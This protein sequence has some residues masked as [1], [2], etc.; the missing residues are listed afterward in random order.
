[1]TFE[2]LFLQFICFQDGSGTITTK[3]LLPVLRS[4][5]QNPTEDEI[6]N[7]VIEYD[8]N[9]DGTI[10]F[11][12]FLEMMIKHSKDIDQTLEI[13]EA[14]KIFDRDGNGYIDAKELKHVVTRM[15]HVLT[16]A[17][18]D[19]FMKEAD[20]DGDGKLDYNEFM[21]MMLESL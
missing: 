2:W 20:L 10:D 21:K 9:G 3:E 18:A 12:E 1:M 16:A 8:V 11:E 14:F 17:E 4:I 7:L 19:E 15:G 6:L 5:G 13:K